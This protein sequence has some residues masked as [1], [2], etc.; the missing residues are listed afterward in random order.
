MNFKHH[1]I[2]QFSKK[3]KNIVLEIFRSSAAKTVLL[4][5]NKLF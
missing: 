4:V 5:E 1:F 3:V 2:Q